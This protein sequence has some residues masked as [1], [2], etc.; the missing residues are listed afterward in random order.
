MMTADGGDVDTPLEP[1]PPL[2][3]SHHRPLSSAAARFSRYL[4]VARHRRRAREAEGTGTA[5]DDPT[6]PPA[7][8]AARTTLQPS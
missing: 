6:N 2:G 7:P 1:P 5:G 4:R 3:A 8:L